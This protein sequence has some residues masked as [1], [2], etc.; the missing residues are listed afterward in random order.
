MSYCG[1]RREERPKLPSHGTDLHRE[2][3]HLI[4][5][6]APLEIPIMGSMCKNL[7]VSMAHQTLTFRRAFTVQSVFR[8]LQSL[9]QPNCGRISGNDHRAQEF[10]RYIPFAITCFGETTVPQEDSFVDPSR[11]AGRK[12]KAPQVPLYLLSRWPPPATLTRCKKKKSDGG[13][14]SYSFH[15]HS[16]AAVGGCEWEGGAISPTRPELA[17]SQLRTIDNE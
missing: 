10:G 1:D 14:E 4:R 6:L 9:I 5:I 3:A 8:L 2:L 15:S 16:T 7:W 12:T 11:I 13:V 17:R